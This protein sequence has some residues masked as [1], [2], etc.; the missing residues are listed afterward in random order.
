MYL[1]SDT[2]MIFGKMMISAE[3]VSTP[4]AFGWDFKEYFPTIVAPVHYV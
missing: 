1:V 3:N 2:I 4:M